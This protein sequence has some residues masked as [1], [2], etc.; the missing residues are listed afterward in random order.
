M[1]FRHELLIGVVLI[2]ILLFLYSITTFWNNGST[3]K[4]KVEDYVVED[5]KTKY[6]DADK[7]GILDDVLSKNDDGKIYYSIRA[8][9]TTNF[10][11]PCPVRIHYYY[12]YP[13]QN[14]ITQPPEYITK[15]CEVCVIP[16]C[17][18]TFEEEAIIGSHTLKGTEDVM[19][20]INSHKGVYPVVEKLE[21]KWKV[22]WIDNDDGLE[23]NIVLS[24]NGNVLE[25][26]FINL[27]NN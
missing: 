15:N 14:F 26:S 27:S 10:Y 13:E 19:Q 18:L 17:T 4:Q 16:P 1:N 9:V 3:E 12:N 8:K 5:L 24:S 21:G 22:I 6:P 20:F 7:I 11:S 23:Y 2:F 25:K